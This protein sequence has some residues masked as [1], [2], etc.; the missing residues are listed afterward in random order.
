[1]KRFHVHVAVTDL[2]ANI[3]FYS[4]LFGQAPSKQK[5]DYAKWMLDDPRLNF[6][7]SS[8]LNASGVNHLGMQADDPQELAALK[9]LADAATGDATLEQGQA[10]CCYARSEKHWT[11]DPQGIAWEHFLTLSDADTLAMDTA[12]SL[13]ACCIPLRPSEPADGQA[14]GICCVPDNV[15]EGAQLC[16]S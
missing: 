3:A 11:V 10:A 14:A 2:P 5:Q 6:A 9:Q 4:K 16:C 1:M 8:R 15:E 12:A 13:G 7:I